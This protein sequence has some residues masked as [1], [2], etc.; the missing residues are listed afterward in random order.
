MTQLP[1]GMRIVAEADVIKAA[2]IEKAKE[3]GY[4][5]NAMLGRGEDVTEAL[6]E[7]RNK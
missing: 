2:E 1:L 3:L 7:V 4:D 5:I 6:K